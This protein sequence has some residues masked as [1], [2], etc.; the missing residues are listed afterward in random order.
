MT[1]VFKEVLADEQMESLRDGCTCARDLA[2]VDVLTSTGM[3]VG[4]L[5]GLDI[6]D[7]DF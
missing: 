5:V 4:E 2:I 6:A 3:R 7:V 1:Q